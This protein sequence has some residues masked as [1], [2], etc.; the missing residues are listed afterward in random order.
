VNADA[1]APVYLTGAI[2]CFA[3]A[4]GLVVYGVWF[5]KKMKRLRLFT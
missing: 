5:W 3:T 4:V 1:G 2:I